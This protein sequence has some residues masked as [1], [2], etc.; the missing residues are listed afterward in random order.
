[1]VGS[2]VR[3]V[4]QVYVWLLRTAWGSGVSPS[5]AWA[6]GWWQMFFKN[7]LSHLTG[8][9]VGSF[10]G[11][12]YDCLPGMVQGTKGYPREVWAEGVS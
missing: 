2:G 6:L 7:L 1:M 8:W 10:R 12:W 5:T 9:K 11:L 3:V 4:C